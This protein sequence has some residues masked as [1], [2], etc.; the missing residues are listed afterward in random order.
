LPVIF[1]NIT[2]EPPTYVDEGI[3]FQSIYEEFDTNAY[4]NDN[5]LTYSEMPDTTLDI[6]I[7]NN[8]RISVTFS[9]VGLLH[10]DDLFNI[11]VKFLIALQ[12]EGVGNRTFTIIY[13][14]NGG[15]VGYDREVVHTLHY[16]YVT[17]PLSAG[18][19]SIKVYWKSEIDAAGINQLN[20]HGGAFDY[21]RALWVLELA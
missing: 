8:S 14:D 10:I 3:L 21:P 20:L 9:A 7:Q 6:S 5:A 11:K 4:I 1:P 13:Y 17:D 12:V 15:A 19:Y 18:T 16:I 2:E